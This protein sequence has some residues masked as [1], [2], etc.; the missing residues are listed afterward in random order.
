MPR[1]LTCKLTQR[2]RGCDATYST[3]D[4]RSRPA[5]FCSALDSAVRPAPRWVLLARS[6]CALIKASRS[7][8]GAR[9]TAAFI[10]L[11]NWCTPANGRAN[12][13][14]SAIQG[15]YSKMFASAATKSSLLHAFRS[16]FVVGDI[17]T[18]RSHVEGHSHELRK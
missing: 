15:E 7:S 12:A 14:C 5:L 9:S 11:N 3:S 18:S 10:T 2:G 1:G 8:T 4:N 17:A 13:A 6:G 16:E